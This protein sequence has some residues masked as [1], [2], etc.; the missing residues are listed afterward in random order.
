M[1]GGWDNTPERILRRGVTGAMIRRDSQMG[2]ETWYHDARVGAPPSPQELAA[3]T[4]W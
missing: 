1:G 2:R 3:L 4:W